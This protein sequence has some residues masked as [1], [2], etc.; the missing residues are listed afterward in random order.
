MNLVETLDKYIKLIKV[1][2][3]LYYAYQFF[4][5][6]SDDYKSLDKIN[7]NKKRIDDIFY[8]YIVDKNFNKYIQF[9]MDSFNKLSLMDEIKI[10]GILRKI[11][12]LVFIKQA[13]YRIKSPESIVNK[14]S[15]YMDEKENGKIKIKKCLNDLF[16]IRFIID[17]YNKIRDEFIYCLNICI[18]KE[19]S[20][21]SKIKLTSKGY[22]GI[23]SPYVA[24][25]IYYSSKSHNDIFPIELQI[26]D[27]VNL[28]R[29]EK[30]HVIYKREYTNWAD[31]Y[32]DI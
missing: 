26:W 23:D 16:G 22:N 29:N 7:L 8:N 20:F 12:N 6:K 4:I 9:Y 3:S 32:N 27:S 11:E 21:K 2:D 5:V 31:Q 15:K 13:R 14:L 18:D 10:D 30:S 19:E 17:D 28:D 24:D 1:I 25:H